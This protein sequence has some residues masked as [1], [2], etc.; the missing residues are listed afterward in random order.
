MSQ[1]A[2][3]MHTMTKPSIGNLSLR[4]PIADQKP[5]PLTRHEQA[6]GGIHEDHPC[7][8]E[9]REN[10]GTP[11][12][13]PISSL[14]SRYGEQANFCR[15]IE[16]EAEQNAERVHLPGMIDDP[17][18]TTKHT[19]QKTSAGQHVFEIVLEETTTVAQDAKHATD[20]DQHHDVGSCDG[21]QE[22]SRGES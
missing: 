15:S 5:W 10:H 13:H 12:R 11:D 19:C 16:A 21:K 20:G 3:K 14:P 18:N 17:E 4:L 7:S 9:G 1:A 8:E 6:L 22:Q 2:A